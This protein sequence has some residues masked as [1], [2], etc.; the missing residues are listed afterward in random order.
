MTQESFIRLPE[1]GQGKRTR[2]LIKDVNGTEVHQ[3]LIGVVDFQG[4][5]VDFASKEKQS[6]ILSVLNEIAEG[7]DVGVT[8]KINVFGENLI[9]A[10]NTLS[11]VNYTVP[12]GKKF[13]FKG[14]II[15]GEE[16]GEFLF[17][18]N[19]GTVSLAR[20][21]GSNRTMTINFIEGMECVEGDIVSI[22]AKNKGDKQRQFESTLFGHLI[23]M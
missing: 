13:I 12:P 22:L 14:G 11:L 7:L 10:D 23:D 9:A 4:V 1:D 21:S 17:Q 18:I 20:N 15:G 19:N 5:E 6:Q 2:T 8:Q 16:S 3:Q